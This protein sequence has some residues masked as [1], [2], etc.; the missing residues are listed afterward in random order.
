[1]YE[2]GIIMKIH[3]SQPVRIEGEPFIHNMNKTY[4]S[5]IAPIV[6]VEVEDPL[7]KDPDSY[8]IVDFMIN[9]SNNTYYVG[10]EP[11]NGEIAKG[12]KLEMAEIAESHGWKAT[13]K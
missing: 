9:Y 1:M 12:K 8:K 10:L 2:R 4:D 3:L 7:W 6:G 13:W 11:Y 5:D